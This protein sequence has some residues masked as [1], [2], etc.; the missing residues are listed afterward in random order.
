MSSSRATFHTKKPLVAFKGARADS[1]SD[2]Y[3][4]GTGC[5]DDNKV[6]I[7][8]RVVALLEFTKQADTSEGGGPEVV[9][10]I[11][12]RQDLARSKVHELGSGQAALE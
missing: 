7:I 12:V 1:I 2:P 3:T 5:N 9:G 6:A 11:S 10:K 8:L 4:S